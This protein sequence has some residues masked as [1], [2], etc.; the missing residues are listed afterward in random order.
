[1]EWILTFHSLEL[2]SSSEVI[3]N[4]NIVIVYHCFIDS[5]HDQPFSS[6]SCRSSTGFIIVRDYTV[7]QGSRAATC[8]LFSEVGHTNKVDNR[9]PYVQGLAV[10]SWRLQEKLS[11]WRSSGRSLS[12]LIGSNGLVIWYQLAATNR[13][14]LA[15]VRV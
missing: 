3:A 11:T 9:L 8:Q 2:T 1:M 7:M 15:A 12:Q 10:G 4:A 5:F 14:E 6:G 13:W